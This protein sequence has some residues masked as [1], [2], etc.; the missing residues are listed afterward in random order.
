VGTPVHHSL[1]AVEPIH[2]PLHDTIVPDQCQT[3]LH[4]LLVLAQFLH[5]VVYFPDGTL[6]RCVHPVLKLF[7]VKGSEHGQKAINQ[8][9]HQRDL[10]HVTHLG[11]S[12]V[13]FLGP[14]FWT[15]HEQAHRSTRRESLRLHREVRDSRFRLFA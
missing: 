7:P 2:V 11:Q 3:S 15:A 1:E 8:F 5:K 12:L 4:S 9:P 10:L 14:V 6:L 13:L